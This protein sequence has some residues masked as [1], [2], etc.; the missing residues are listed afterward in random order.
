MGQKATP[1]P[2]AQPKS[3][4]LRKDD[5]SKNGVASMAEIT[6]FQERC[7]GMTIPPI[8]IVDADHVLQQ[9]LQ[10]THVLVGESGS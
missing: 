3:V 10:F 6:A 4:D 9:Q 5:S 8:K 1:S 7:S 2:V